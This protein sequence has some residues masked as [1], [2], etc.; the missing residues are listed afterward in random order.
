MVQIP[1]FVKIAATIR[2]G[3]VYL[4]EQT[5][6]KLSKNPHFFVILNEDPLSTTELV[7]VNAT[8]NIDGRKRFVAKRNLPTETLVVVDENDCGFLSHES[9]FDCNTPSVFS[10]DELLE[11][12]ENGVFVYKDEVSEEILTFLIEG[13]KASPMVPGRIKNSL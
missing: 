6:F 5:H 12:C 8:S 1:P 9:V 2:Q 7:V 3:S 10:P 13:V 4:I 11:R